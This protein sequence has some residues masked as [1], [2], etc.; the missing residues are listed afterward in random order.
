MPSAGML[1]RWARLPCEALEPW[2]RAFSRVDSGFT[3]KNPSFADEPGAFRLQTS[4]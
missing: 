3:P 2:E 4:R 1:L